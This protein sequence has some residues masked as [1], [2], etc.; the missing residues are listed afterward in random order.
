[1]GVKRGGVPP[2]GD[3]LRCKLLRARGGVIASARLW[4]V[5]AR[6]SR[7]TTSRPP[8]RQSAPNGKPSP[9]SQ[10]EVAVET[11]SESAR[12]AASQFAALLDG[13]LEALGVR[14]PEQQAAFL[15][16]AARQNVENLT[17][18]RSQSVHPDAFSK[19]LQ[20][21][22]A[23][24]RTRQFEPIIAPSSPH[25]ALVLDKGCSPLRVQSKLRDAIKGRAIPQRHLYD[26]A[27][28]AHLWQEWIRH[29]PQ[30]AAM[31]NGVRECATAWSSR[32]GLLGDAGSDLHVLSLG[33]GTGEKE[34]VA[35]EALHRS[36]SP[37]PVRLLLVDSSAALLAESAREVTK[38]LQGVATTALCADFES[39]HLQFARNHWLRQPEGAPAAVRLVMMLGNVFG[40]L[41]DEQT[42]VSRL[43]TK[44]L[45]P[46]DLLWI[47]V[48]TAAADPKED[49]AEARLR[50]YPVKALDAT[51]GLNR[52]MLL[53][54]LRSRRLDPAGDT[55][56]VELQLHADGPSS[57]PGSYTFRYSLQVE[58]KTKY[59]VDVLYARRYAE[60]GLERWFEDL[61]FTKLASHSVAFPGAK[62][63]AGVTHLLL[64]YQ[65]ASSPP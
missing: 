35:L 36:G 26:C 59:C 22:T 65:G 56:E 37:K 45:R 51:R 40:N 4:I 1:M 27:E 5:R 2:R 38:A 25:I 42:F 63:V 12:R 46:G 30:R 58:R 41:I 6:E 57:I 62:M 14:N 60:A 23:G 9:V 54:F 28:A 3:G 16:L 32:A 15:K 50:D 10:P 55:A 13:V 48:G 11:A 61:G 21:V 49:P 64:R 52:L 29:D 43:I 19:I 17:A 34:I 20:A 33:S 53:P 18:G 44:L 31:V 7:V 39:G 24:I 8:Q 47:E